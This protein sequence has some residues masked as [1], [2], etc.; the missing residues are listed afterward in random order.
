[1]KKA[2]FFLPFL[3]HILCAQSQALEIKTKFSGM[4]NSAQAMALDSFEKRLSTL[5]TGQVF[6]ALVDSFDLY[7]V[8][9]TG[10]IISQVHRTLYNP[11]DFYFTKT[12]LQQDVLE[13]INFLPTGRIKKLMQSQNGTLSEIHYS[14]FNLKEYIV[15]NLLGFKW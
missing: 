4:F 14:R 8:A 7:I 13:K 5:D 2:I 10:N 15:A 3:L 1:M 11:D 12:T 6:C 9:R